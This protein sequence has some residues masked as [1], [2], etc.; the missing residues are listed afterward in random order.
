M[1]LTDPALR[2][3]KP[4]DKPRK[5]ADGGGLYLLIQP[6]GGKWWRLD[7]RHG[8]KRKTLSMGT[9]PD[10]PL[11]DARQRRDEARRLLANGIDPGEHRKLTK[12]TLPQDADSFEAVAREWFAKFAPG[13]APTHAEKIIRR[14]ERE[15]FPWLG[16]R[17]V[18]DITAPEL[19]TVLRRIE[20]RGRLETA[21]RAHQN[22][23]RV[24]RYAV[25]TGRAERDPS[26]D[27]RGALPPATKRHHAAIIDP[28][29]IAELLRV[30]DGYTGSFVTACALRL[31][32]LLFVRPGELR[33]AEWA[34][35]YLDAAEWRIPAAKMKMRAPHVV[36]LADQA[37]AI[38]RELH[39]LTGRGRYVFPG[40]RSSE[41]PMSENTVNAALRRL[42]YEKDAM[43]GHGFRTLASTTLHEQGWP[44]D[45][46][47]RQLAHAE[48]NKIKA[49][50]N[51]AEH[52]PE[53]RKMMQAWADYLDG[54]R[55]GGVVVPL[56]RA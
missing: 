43:T 32:P 9:Y 8:G 18:G 14:L 22:C 23:G 34:E 29:A 42:G 30:L 5:L 12:N 11:A 56:R 50:Y 15:V 36:P 47:E 54:L 20:A 38:L 40:A 52:L 3:A 49:A 10:T 41:R 13:W 27:L 19:L 31:A 1:P 44:S 6:A 45:I 7:Y 48:R 53:R 35:I 4:A 21:H 55:A 24:F 16:A 46:I 51:R 17:P 39:P 33:R 37:L 28:K 26:G 25:A 2:N